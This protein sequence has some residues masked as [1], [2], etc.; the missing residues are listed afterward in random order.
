[1]LQ[2]GSV[3][4]LRPKEDH[5]RYDDGISKHTSTHVGRETSSS[6]EESAIPIV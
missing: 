4:I 5:N 3:G 6:P 2:R 1:M